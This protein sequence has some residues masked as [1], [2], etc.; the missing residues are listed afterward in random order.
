MVSNLWSSETKSARIT[1]EVICIESFSGNSICNSIDWQ[2]RVQWRQYQIGPLRRCCF[3]SNMIGQG[4]AEVD[5]L[6]IGECSLVDSKLDVKLLDESG[7]SMWCAIISSV[8]VTK[9]KSFLRQVRRRIQPRGLCVVR[10]S[11]RRCTGGVRT[12]VWIP[13]ATVALRG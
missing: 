12:Y 9:A 6:G 2:G 4:F 5:V 13:N 11:H 8:N 7:R 3:S 1:M 10:E